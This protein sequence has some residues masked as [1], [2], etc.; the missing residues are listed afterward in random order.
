MVSRGSIPLLSEYLP[1]DKLRPRPYLELR[2]KLLMLIKKRSLGKRSERRLPCVE[3]FF[4]LSERL[5]LLALRPE[6]RGSFTTRCLA[7]SITIEPL[8]PGI[9]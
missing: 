1:P 8:L 4:Y 3:I 5:D 9:F 7:F 2:G 6:K